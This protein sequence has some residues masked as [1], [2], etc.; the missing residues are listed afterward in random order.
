MVT[1]GGVFIFHADEL[2]DDDD[3]PAPY[4]MNKA[5]QMKFRVQDYAEYKKQA[6]LN[7][8]TMQ[9]EFIEREYQRLKAE[10]TSKNN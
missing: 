9:D 7:K 4:C 2:N 3:I 8:L 1:R 5:R 6:N 10:I